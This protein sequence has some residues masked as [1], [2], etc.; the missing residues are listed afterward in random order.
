LF[1]QDLNKGQKTVKKTIHGNKLIKQIVHKPVSRGC[2]LLILSLLVLPAVSM[3]QQYYDPGLIQKTVDRTPAEYGPTGVR[4]GSFTLKPG[5]ELT[6]VN[7]DNIYYL[8]ES[9]ASDNILHIRPWLNFLSDWSRHALNLRL[10]ADIARYQDFE[11][12]DYEDYRA[13]IDG[14]FDVRRNSAFSY[15]MAYMNLHEDRSSPDDS[16]GIHPTR[17]D[18]YG[19]DV[20]YGHSFNR[21]TAKL[22]YR[23]FYTDY[24]DN[25]RLDG[26]IIDQQ[27]RDRTRDEWALRLDYGLAGGKTAL[28][29]G[30]SVNNIDY[31]QVFDSDGYM[32][33]S[34]GY[35]YF[36][37]VSLTITSLLIGDV[38]ATYTK[39]DYDEPTFADVDGW[40]LGAALNWTP[41]EATNV[42][43]RLETTPQETI[44][45]GSSGYMSY[46]YAVRIQ[47]DF[48]RNF[49]GNLRFSYTDNNYETN[50]GGDDSLQ[51]TDVFRAEIGLTY[52][53]NPFISLS[54]GYA[55]TRQKANISSY[56]YATNR[57]FVT[58][59]LQY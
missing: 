28:I 26:E 12:E 48:R 43:F 24:D 42:N 2:I 50:D 1:R 11:T 32:R 4:M 39:Q 25:I 17:F 36:G 18:Y 3:A 53:F 29:A 9:V 45:S 15:Y 56:E 21:L 22:N 58:L 57:W 10:F 7:N 46:L 44:Q 33:S 31:D 38:Y 16:G 59:G 5:V 55:Y 13:S 52:L 41:T 34:E 20:G 37:G 51:Y 8:E 54:G 30:A 49:M 47:Q 27:A 14:R 40:G 35:S 19:Y 6:W 23:K